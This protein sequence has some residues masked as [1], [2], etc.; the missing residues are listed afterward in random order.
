MPEKLCGP[1]IEALAAQTSNSRTVKP[2]TAYHL[3][4]TGVRVTHIDKRFPAGGPSGRSSALLHLFY[5]EPELSQLAAGGIEIL[6]NM[7]ELTG[8][9]SDSREVGMLTVGG[10]DNAVNYYQAA[11]NRIHDQENGDIRV[12]SMAEYQDMAPG[13]TTGGIEVAVWEPHSGYAD[14]PVPPARWRNAPA[15]SAPA[16]A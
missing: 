15:N 10:A 5:M 16:P 4:S 13:F 14:P 7:P 11:A 2:R 8:Y 3:V 9:P 6:R 12:L 1:R